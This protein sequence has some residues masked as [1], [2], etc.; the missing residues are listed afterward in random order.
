[1]VAAVWTPQLACG[2]APA[3]ERRVIMVIPS[4]LTWADITETGTPSMWRLASEGALGNLNSRPRIRRAGEPANALE[5]ALTLSA[6]NWATPDPSALG[7]FGA[8]ETV[9]SAE[10][11]AEQPSSRPEPEHAIAFRGL[12]ASQ[13]INV[14][15][16]SG[17]VLGTLGQALID[18]GGS[19]SAI[20]NS[21]VGGDS[22]SSPWR[23]ERPA[24]IVAADKRGL[25]MW[26]DVSRGL[27]AD[28][29][30]APYDRCTDL[31]AFEREF[32]ACEASAAAH[33]G[34]ALFVLDPGDEYRARHHARNASDGARTAQRAQ[35]LREADDVVSMALRHARSSDIVVIACQAPSDEAPGVAGFSP[36]LVSGAH[37]RGYL[38]SASTHRPGLVTNP[39]VTAF[40]LRELALPMPSDVIGST[41]LATPAPTTPTERIARLSARDGT[42]VSIESM[43]RRFTDVFAWVFSAVLALAG[44][45]VATRRR[46]TVRVR[47]LA[48]GGVNAA[49]LLL[50][51]V[52]TAT[53]TMFLL[54]PDTGSRSAARASLVVASAVLFAIV[55][56]AWRL[57]G[58]RVAFAGLLLAAVIL[59]IGDQLLGAPLSFATLIG[60]SPLQ[61]SRYYGIGNEPAAFLLG[62]ALVGIALVLDGWPH[63]H[64]AA[65]VRRTGIP[66]VGALVLVV[67]AA[68]MAGANVGVLLWGTVGFGVMWALANGQ[69]PR[70]QHALAALAVIAVLL[71]AFSAIDLAGHGEQTHLARALQSVRHGDLSHLSTTVARKALT[72]ARLLTGTG[73]TIVFVAIAGFFAFLRLDRQRE[74]S[75]VVSQHPTFGAA[76]TAAVSAGVVG[77]LTEDTGIKVPAFILIPFAIA[78]V[79]LALAE[80]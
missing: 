73:W 13:R 46:L 23:I 56:A 67:C 38:T 80:D 51:S 11:T 43:R 37:L 57:L 65:H 78:A 36:I 42:A 33:G 47:K 10:V 63:A 30:L 64:W 52:L 7:A 40:L 61:G 77:F 5:G 2:A 14:A 22:D 59:L 29:P 54:S 72:S 50:L 74:L 27:L 6:G 53:W 17:A 25:V 62:S 18:A 19:T 26:G 58:L 45:L 4:G 48:T 41:L 20:G 16:A 66:A 44:V 79:W 9:S 71:A 24:G 60:Y 31:A 76:L 49:G 8:T 55:V 34:P 69:R 32:S 3:Q 75:R 35:A 21:D 12:A 39:D 15:S 70:W 1:M 68:P 28:S